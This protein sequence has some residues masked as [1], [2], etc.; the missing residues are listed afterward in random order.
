MTPSFGLGIQI[1]GLVNRRG[2]N[3]AVGV[4]VGPVTNPS[5][6]KYVVK[7]VTT[8]IKV[9]VKWDNIFHMWDAEGIHYWS[10]SIRAWD[11][12]QHQLESHREMQC[13]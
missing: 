13:Q 11:D 12:M 1:M 8:G 10:E 2:L 7:L 6:G 4:V 3:K 5:G 9:V